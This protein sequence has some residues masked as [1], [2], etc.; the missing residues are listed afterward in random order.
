MAPEPG[1]TAYKRLVD[2]NLN[3]PRRM[4]RDHFEKR[5]QTDAEGIN[6]LL[7]RAYTEGL[8]DGFAQGVAYAAEKAE[9]EA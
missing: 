3:E 6:A 7:D 1:P 9:G 2:F 4:L 8:R 5:A